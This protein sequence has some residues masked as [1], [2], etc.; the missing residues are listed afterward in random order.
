MRPWIWAMLAAAGLGLMLMS[1]H[2]WV[3]GD[4]EA[5][6]AFGLLFV[7]D[8]VAASKLDVGTTSSTRLR[9]LPVDA[10]VEAMLKGVQTAMA[11]GA[12]VSR[13]RS[14]PS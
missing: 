11:S 14:V 2:R 3:R 6:G 7:G 8:G 1:Y 13:P 4:P 9:Y 5:P 12:Q 10:T